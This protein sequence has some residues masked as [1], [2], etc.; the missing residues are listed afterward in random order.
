M[1]STGPTLEH[2]VGTRAGRC[3]YLLIVDLDTMQ[4]EAMQNPLVA[5]RGPAA[6]KLFATIMS[7]ENVHIILTGSCGLNRLRV[8]SD[9]G[10]AILVGMTG[11]VGGIIER[12][13][14]FCSNEVVVERGVCEICVQ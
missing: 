10:I 8:L 13:K 3:G 6:G 1:T 9:A 14:F 11:R 5:L 7:Q 2:C 4:Y 12:F